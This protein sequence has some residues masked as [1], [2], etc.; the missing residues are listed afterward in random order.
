LIK[1]TKEAKLLEELTKVK[2]R[3]E[4]LS[5]LKIEDKKMTKGFDVSLINTRTIEA[6][7]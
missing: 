2:N 3:Q 5:N 6:L 4:K 7:I 1:K